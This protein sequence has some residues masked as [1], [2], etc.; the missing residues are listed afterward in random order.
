[1][2]I[3]IGLCFAHD[4]CHLG[5]LLAHVG[6][7]V[8]IG[9]FLLGVTSYAYLASWERDLWCCLTQSQRAS[10]SKYVETERHVDRMVE[11]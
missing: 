2:T 11:F 4:I 5:G 8:F 10:G 6:R 9:T 1:M 3:D 7:I